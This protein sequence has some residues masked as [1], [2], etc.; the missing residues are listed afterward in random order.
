MR[1]SVIT[2]KQLQQLKKDLAGSGGKG[3][4]FQ[5]WLVGRGSKEA[6]LSGKGQE[7]QGRTEEEQGSRDREAFE[8]TIVAKVASLATTLWE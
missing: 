8:K 6:H 1:P 2:R 7:D 5:P 3:V 4:C